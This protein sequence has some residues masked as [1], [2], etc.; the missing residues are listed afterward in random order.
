MEER[1]GMMWIG[2]DKMLKG[3]KSR[4]VIGFGGAL[5]LFSKK[6]DYKPEAIL[7]L[8]QH[9]LESN[10]DIK[11]DKKHVIGLLPTSDAK[12]STKLLLAVDSDDDKKG[13]IEFLTKN[14]KNPAP[15]HSPENPHASKG[16][17]VKYALESSVANSTVGQ[18]ILK[19]VMDDQIWKVIDEMTSVLKEVKGEEVSKKFR[20]SLVKG[21]TKIAVLYNN[22]LIS[23]EIVLE[24][25]AI[26]LKLSSAVVDFYQM[27]SIFDGDHIVSLLTNL[28]NSLD[29]HLSKKL[30]PKNY[31]LVE[32]LYEILCD[33]S[34]I[35]N[36]FTKGKWPQLAV[37]AKILDDKAK[38]K[39]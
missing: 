13:W 34:L 19:Q 1:E 10:L 32:L 6:E 36:F 11:S 15:S 33:G 4:F 23:N 22:K 17:G 25:Y 9:S 37:I 31:A 35:S 18:K 5:F 12:K 39:H 38:A 14:M 27:P 3:W 28:K 20:A 8:T 29:T 26:M 7:L 30:S 21:G 16:K 2:K 24:W